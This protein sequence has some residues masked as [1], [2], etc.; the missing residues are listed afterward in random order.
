MLVYVVFGDFRAAP[1]FHPLQWRNEKACVHFTGNECL[2]QACRLHIS[3]NRSQGILVMH[4][5]SAISLPAPCTLCVFLL[6][7]KHMKVEGKN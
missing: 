4:I 5:L 2:I 3:K 6:V 1:Y 7:H